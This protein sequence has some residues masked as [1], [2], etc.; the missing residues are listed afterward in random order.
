MS[1]IVKRL[2]CWI[3]RRNWWAFRLNGWLRDR[4]GY[5]VTADRENERE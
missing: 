3:G 5:D 2:L 4:L 1:D